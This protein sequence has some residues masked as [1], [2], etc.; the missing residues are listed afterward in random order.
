MKYR[1][2]VY[3]KHKPE[4]RRAYL[5]ELPVDADV[6]P[7]DRLCV[8]DSHGEQIVTAFCENWLASEKMTR[9]LCEANGGYFPPAQVIGTVDTIRLTQE[10]VNKF[11]GSQDATWPPVKQEENQWW[12]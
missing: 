11:D 7:N 9:T 6:K 4:D 3:C 10:V 1:N 8:I 2:L 5:Y 12:F